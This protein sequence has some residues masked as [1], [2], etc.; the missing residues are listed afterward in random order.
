V[1]KLWTDYFQDH[2]R[3]QAFR[4]ESGLDY[5][6]YGNSFVSLGFPF[7]K[8][9][10]CK[11]CN[12]RDEAGKIR[13]QWIFT[14]FQFR[15]TCPKCGYIGDALAKDVYYKNASG[16]KTIRWNAEDI[17]VS[18]NDISGEHTYFYTIPAVVRNDI[19]IGRKD[20]LEGIPQVFIQAMR[21]QKGVIFSKDNFFHMRRPTLATQDRG[22]GTP[23][24]LPVL[25]DTFYLQ[26][27]KKANECV[28]PSTLI[29]TD[30]GL[31]PASE[32]D[33]GTIVRTHTGS[34]APVTARAVRPIVEA[35]GDYAVE[36]T[37]TSMRQMPSVFSDNHPLFVLRRNE[38]NR[39]KDSKASRGS[40]YV[41]RNPDLYAFDWVDASAVTVGDY[42]GYPTHRVAEAQTI[43]IGLY[44]DLVT[45]D[46]F[47]YS[48]VSKE[49][50]LAF[51]ALEAGEHVAHDAAGRVAKRHIK[52]GTEP[53]R[54][55]RHVELDAD[56]AYIAG[57]YLGDGSCGSRHVD[58]SMG[59]DD[60]GVELQEAIGRVFGIDCASHPSK[61]SRGWSLTACETIFTALMSGWISGEA[62]TKRI[63]T[64]ILTAPDA[65]LLEFLRGYLEAD[66]YTALSVRND[67]SATVCCAN[68]QLIYQLWSLLLS[69]GC[70]STLSERVSYDTDI[71]KA[72]GSVQHLEGGRPTFF[73]T[74]RSKSARRLGQ[75]LLGEPAETVTSGKSG[76]F[77]HGYFA[78]RVQRVA[79]VDCAEVISFEV[80]GEHTFCTPGMA[81]HN[82]ILLEHI[83]PLRIL[84]PQA[85]SGSSDP[86]MTINLLD[87][88]DQ[89]AAEI[90]R[91]RMDSNY[92][93]VMP[94]PLGNQTIGGDGK[95]LM[96]VQ[97]IAEWSEQILNGMGVTTNFIKGGQGYS[98][99][100]VDMRMMENMFLGYISRQKALAQF[101]MEQVASYLGWP[102]ANIRFKPF[103]M[104]DDLQ[105]K[106][107]LFQLNA[108]NKISDTT[109][110]ADSDFSQDEENAIMIRETDK[111]IE[112]M[113]KQQL[114]MATI[115][116]E[117][118]QIMMK[119]Q[120]KAQQDAQKAMGA[121]VAPGEPGGADMQGAGSAPGGAGGGAPG[122][123]MPGA[124]Q[125]GSAA[126]AAA[127]GL[128]APQ[129]PAPGAGPS[130]Q[131]FLSQ[132][133]SQ[134]TGQQKMQDQQNIGLLGTAEAQAKLLVTLPKN[135]QAVALQNISLQSPELAE[136]VQQAMAELQP[137]S[138]GGEAQPQVDQ[139]PM[140]NQRPP[141]RATGTA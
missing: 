4:V 138:P 108:A 15:L 36:I 62:K 45:T 137:A 8:Y 60:T 35:R 94:L 53:K 72:D 23:L 86:Y 51:E 10:Y 54:F 116:G 21:E 95:A 121:P 128:Q 91:W 61:M 5:F 63:P 26:L 29:E 123:D 2:L 42:I 1:K 120:T 103:K 80:A 90:S 92:I 97:E 110:L 112:A 16:I 122:Q 46:Q 141:R 93:P 77:V 131:D 28:A 65:V 73:W 140:P 38:I 41:L 105:R 118:Q 18:Y 68:K 57:W 39:R 124:L 134:L 127:G 58:F 109:L 133:S 85:G 40:T 13:A 107:Y 70:I 139:R 114:A 33:V 113:K 44:A 20:T 50:A 49:T 111:R 67:E 125:A 64:E 6:A 25:K 48:G 98:G 130:P 89:V 96:L 126:D 12:F 81:T 82:S 47:V 99:S 87:W 14:S 88:R 69:L 115:Q 11:S 34:L 129:G 37:L 132:V 31:V 84:F 75:L 102:K 3:W 76:F 7:K 66:G 59:P 135:Q 56:L 19:V 24:L 117:A 43:D 22:W 52:K 74:V 83:V 106:A 79:V 32:V 71:T 30:R 9:L 119:F 78:T 55:T 27:M 136:L 17:E 104:A 100:M 101:V